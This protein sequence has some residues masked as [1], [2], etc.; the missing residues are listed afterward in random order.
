MKKIT[1]I[2]V[3][4]LIALSA[5]AQKVVFMP[6]W[7][8]QSQFAGFYMA[9]EMG[10]YAQEGLDVEIRHIPLNSTESVSGYLL[11]GDVQIVGQQL[12]QS[13]IS[14]S[15]GNDI[16]NVM[17]MTQVS[18]LWCVSHTPVEKPEDL[19]GMTIGRWKSGY[20]E[21]CDMLETYKGLNIEWI[22]FING[23]NLYVYGAVDATLCY[24]FSEYIALQ[25][26]VGDIPENHVL[27]FSEFGYE[28]PEDGLYVLGS[29]YEKN[30]DVV[31]RFVR[32][33]KKGWEYVRSHRQQAVD[34]SLK[35]C[36]KFHIVTNRA[37]QEMMLSEYLNLMVNP[38]TAKVD[39]APVT[40]P[41]YNEMVDALMNTGYITNKPEYKEFVR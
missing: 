22:P 35:Y 3:S 15:D 10:F 9:L 37:M 25:L 20:S 5:N 13:I 39:Y 40:E 28:C 29:Y 41:V 8:A 18:G 16:V 23:I 21:F 27:K 26:A 1:V 38:S 14:R 4:L 34:E 17:Q 11:S 31:D 19:N 12:I 33:S 30:K 2:F 32:A 6:Q 36:Q 7:T 24:S